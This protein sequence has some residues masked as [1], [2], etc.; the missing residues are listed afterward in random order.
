M[1]SGKYAELCNYLSEKNP[2]CF[3]YIIA[4]KK[5]LS[6][7]RLDVINR[8]YEK[9]GDDRSEA[10]EVL[11]K[12]IIK[13][14]EDEE[15]DIMDYFSKQVKELTRPKVELTCKEHPKYQA[16]RKPRSGCETCWEMYRSKHATD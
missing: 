13:M 6:E 5:D 12:I 9:H 7:A 4:V 3:H 11:L 15:E 2:D 8:V 14:L 10:R 16:I 1:S